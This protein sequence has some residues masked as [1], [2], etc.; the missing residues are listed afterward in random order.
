LNCLRSPMDQP[1]TK[2]TDA[3][4]WHQATTAVLALDR[5]G[6]PSSWITLETAIHLLSTDRVITALGDE[7][8]VFYGG[9]N[10]ISGLRSSIKVNSILLTRA[11]VVPRL[12]SA[13]Y[14]PPLTNRALFNRDG[15]I[16]QYCGEY[17]P[18]RQLTRDHVKPRSRGG[19][20]VWSNVV[21][22]CF[23]CNSVRKRNRTPSEWGVELLS[24]PY[25]PCYAEHLLLQ[26]RNILAD[27]AAFIQARVRK[28]KQ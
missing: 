26:G 19:K 5:A 16:C 13:D 6:N 9:T 2:E 11:R 15:H 1:T 23:V 21:A 20:D 28:R 27:Q 7:S 25:T 8:R 14:A 24:V 17:F 4:Q 22:S 18:A 3:M 10:R 12:W